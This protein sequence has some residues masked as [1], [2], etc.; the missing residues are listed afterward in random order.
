MPTIKRLSVAAAILLAAGCSGGGGSN[1]VPKSP[2]LSNPSNPSNPSQPQSRV[3]TTVKIHIPGPNANAA[4]RRHR[5]FVSAAT[6]FVLVSETDKT[7]TNELTQ[8]G[9]DVSAGSAACTSD[10]SGSAGSRT[11]TVQIDAAPTSGSNYDYFEF[12]TYSSAQTV[13][14]PDTLANAVPNSRLGS[15]RTQAQITLDASNTISV[16]LD[17]VIAS[18]SVVPSVVSGDGSQPLSAQYALTASDASGETIIAG[19][20]DPYT[21]G[22]NYPLSFSLSDSPQADEGTNSSDPSY[23]S[24]LTLTPGGPD[25][26]GTPLTS[27]F[28][29][30]AD[31]LSASYEP[32][33]DVLG[34]YDTISFTPTTG[35]SLPVESA[36]FAPIFID[37]SMA[38]PATNGNNP[39][40]FSQN[41][42]S[43]HNVVTD[44]CDGPCTAAK[45]ARH[46]FARVH[47]TRHRNQAGNMEN[48]TGNNYPIVSFT[49][50]TQS[51]TVTPSEYVPSGGTQQAF[52]PSLSPGCT[53]TT[54]GSNP[55]SSPIINITPTTSSTSFV[56]MATSTVSNATDYQTA[57]DASGQP[58][59]DCT[60]TFT[61]TNGN[62]ALLEVTNT[63]TSGSTVQVGGPTFLA[64]NYGADG[65]NLAVDVFAAPST[66]QSGPVIGSLIS[67][68]TAE[69]YPTGVAQD[70][71][72]DVFVG[73]LG[74]GVKEF[75]APNYG[76][77]IN[78]GNSSPV[79]GVAYHLT[80]ASSSSMEPT[81]VLAV[82]SQTGT[83]T[84]YDESSGSANDGAV[85]GTLTL[86]TVNGTLP[87]PVGVVFDSNSDLYVS[88]TVN[89][90][91]YEYTAGALSTYYSETEA[92][93][94]P[95]I[96]TPSLTF[97]MPP[98]TVPF[99]IAVDGQ[100][101][102]FVADNEH[103]DIYIYA[104]DNHSQTPNA[105]VTDGNVTYPCTGYTGLALQTLGSTDYVYA[106]CVSSNSG[107]QMFTVSNNMALNTTY[108]TMAVSTNPT[109]TPVWISF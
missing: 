15:A 106:S 74:Y 36:I 62:S 24:F 73:F 69:N 9:T 101:N 35:S 50:A 23:S 38:T 6:N 20:T 48:E 68:I 107:L 31:Y 58:I 80:G 77:S 53:V 108:N 12:D 61:D 82:A 2:V 60:V 1:A 81:A 91:V 16:V 7:F 102:V 5:A 39:P 49:A 88:D 34:Y 109:I 29:Q 13:D 59:T 55:T 17:G 14:G 33:F 87:Q 65:S 64:S 54:G 27:T 56:I 11:C 86:P 19:S 3:K 37:A 99:Q 8:V 47:T 85:L 104:N 40:T 41:D 105:T 4:T 100:H 89:S 83:V 103:G 43:Y 97:K 71:A 66:A 46:S 76:T 75:L 25:A 18:Y 44:A 84:V 98:G 21:D 45:H 57:T 32:N 42:T 22:T 95:A 96:L 92:G 28:E 51:I 94:A 90:L 26:T 10:N 72:H 93:T 70:A 79:E 78:I 67:S 63:S 52:T 30:S